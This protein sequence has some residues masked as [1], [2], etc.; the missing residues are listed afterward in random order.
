MKFRFST[1]KTPTGRSGLKSPDKRKTSGI[2]GIRSCANKS[3]EASIG[4]NYGSDVE[5]EIDETEKLRLDLDL[6]SDLE[7]DRKRATTSAKR[8]ET[9]EMSDLGSDSSGEEYQ[10]TGTPS[11]INKPS[12]NQEELRKPAMASRKKRSPSIQVQNIFNSFAGQILQSATTNDPIISGIDNIVPTI[13]EPHIFDP[14][15]IPKINSNGNIDDPEFL[16]TY[17]NGEDPSKINNERLVD[18]RAFSL[19]GPEGYFEQQHARFRINANS[20]IAP[21]LTR[22]EFNKAVQ[23]NEIT[24]ISSLLPHKYLY[25]QWCFEL[26]QGF[27]INFYGVGSKLSIINDFAENYF[28][29]WWTENTEDPLP[30]V[31][32]V[33]GYNPNVDFKTIVLEIAN[34]LVKDNTATKLPKHVSDTVPFLVDYMAKEPITPR[35]LLIVHNIDGESLR[36]DKTQGLFSQLAAIPQILAITS[37]DHI[38]APLLWDSSKSKNL[39]LI[40]HDLTTYAPYIAELSFKDILNLGKSKKFVG[41]LGAKF[42]LRSLTENHRNLYRLLLEGQLI[43]MK[44]IADTRG[45]GLKGV[46]KF[47]LELRLLYSLCL[48]EFIVSNE[49]TFR[50]FLKEYLDHKMCQL[51]KD[52]SGLELLFVPFTYSEME[53]LYKE[54]FET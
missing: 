14:L 1:V 7:S 12:L 27:N 40:W 3:I 52:S 22:D 31:F 4:Q 15:P 41:S 25:H 16:Q 45:S 39:N 24:K 47:A 49:V 11:R 21:K 54:E 33:N 48:D 8:K 29:I 46:V 36:S 44:P 38:N 26:S 43:R 30:K 32:V 2:S 50:T 5:L 53:T 9:T 35:L 18:E 10:E 20:L 23:Q 19:E 17:M 42:V 37:T 6:D 51:V 34:V 28:G 13:H